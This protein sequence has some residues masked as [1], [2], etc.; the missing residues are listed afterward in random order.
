M[1]NELPQELKTPLQSLLKASQGASIDEYTS[2]LETAI[3]ACDIVL[4][5]VDK[6]KEKNL[7][8]QQR[9]SLI[10]QLNSAN[11]PALVLHIG[12]LLLF[13]TITQNTLNASGRFVP[14][15]IGFLQPHLPAS[16]AELLTTLQGN[17]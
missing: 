4:K 17:S 10:D 2:S 12:V 3:A 15:I 8:S 6:K 7:G 5:K 9:H 13:H 11:D 14:Q 1:I 16:T